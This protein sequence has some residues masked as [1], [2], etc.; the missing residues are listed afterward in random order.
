MC[1]ASICSTESPLSFL[2][3]STEEP[4]IE[5]RTSDDGDEGNKDLHTSH[6]L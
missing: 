3:E 6:T 4:V 2:V 1:V 5:D